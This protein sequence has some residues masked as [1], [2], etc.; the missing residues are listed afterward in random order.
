MK[1]YN[2]IIESQIMKWLFKGKALII[3]GARQVGK[4]TLLTSISNKLGNTLWLNADENNTRTRLTNPSLEALKGIVGDYRVV[5][6]DEIQ[7]IEN[8][9]LL[10]KLLVDN[11]K[12]VQFLATGSSALEISDTIFEP[13]TG[14]YFLFHL[15]PFSLAELYP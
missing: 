2:R 1:E 10:L 7:R 4:T 3:I 14:R 12:G 11:F 8:A 13:M 5:I 15:Y 9:G 6:I